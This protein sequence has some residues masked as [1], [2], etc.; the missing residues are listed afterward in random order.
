MLDA[1][2]H[3]PVLGRRRRSP[4]PALPVFLVMDKMGLGDAQH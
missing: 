4:S 2:Q 3:D 1:G